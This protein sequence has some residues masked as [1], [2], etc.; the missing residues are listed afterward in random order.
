MGGRITTITASAVLALGLAAVSAPAA[1][2]PEF[3]W[4]MQSLWQAGSVN[5]Q[6]FIEFC[7]RVKE[8]TGGRLEIEPLPVGTIVAYNET[9]E[10]VGAGILEGHHSGAA[11]FS[12]K[13]A[14]F[15]LLGDLNGAYENPYQMQLWYEYRDGLELARELYEQY[16]VYFIGPVWWGVESLP[17]KQPIRSVEDLQGVKV[18][19]PE[20]IGQDIFARV[21]AA[22]VNLPGAEVY[23]ALERGVID[24]ADWG[25]L[26]M[27]HDLGYHD[28]APY[29]IYPGFH[30]MPAGDVAVNLDLWN[31]LPDDIKAIL[32]VAVRDFARDMVQR[33]ELE[34]IRA[35]QEAQEKGIELVSWPDDER[36]RFREV[37]VEVWA[38]YGERSPMAQRVYESQVG[39]LKEIGI[40]A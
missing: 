19:S 8:L 23:T 31:A 34:D 22:P 32:E 4:R 16:N 25:T 38:E 20:G 33:V 26:G 37:A 2:Q 30:S 36:R 12:G 7:E 24:A 21:G 1:A 6:V 3:Q 5:Q 39:W 14:A 35:V 29:P 27:N 9:L 15:A 40:I 11:Y 28:I 10:S 18:R 17:S 13:D